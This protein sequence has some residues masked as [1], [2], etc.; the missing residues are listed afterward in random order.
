MAARA[1]SMSTARMWRTG[2]RSPRPPIN[3]QMKQRP[4]Q[5]GHAERGAPYDAVHLRGQGPGLHPRWPPSATPSWAPRSLYRAQLDTAAP[6]Y[7][8]SGYTWAGVEL[9]VAAA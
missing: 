3:A 1:W 4:G 5:G 8:V 9:A 2:S 6:R 7:F